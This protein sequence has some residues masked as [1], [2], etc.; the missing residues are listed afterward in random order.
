M[1]KG[2][3]EINYQTLGRVSEIIS[4]AK[5]MT[6]VAQS[7]VAELRDLLGLKGCALMLLDRKTKELEVTAAAGLSDEYLN[8]GPLSAAKSIAASMTDGPV[9]IYNVEDD[10]R[11]QYPQEAVR[12]GVKSILSV[13][14]VLRGKPQGVLRLYTNEPWEFNMRDLTFVQ[15]IAELL[16]LALYTL[17]VTGAHKTS[18]E[19]L[20]GLRPAARPANG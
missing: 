11:L 1:R 9:G 7:V 8:K 16:A 4:S 5:D 12:E 19:A 3:K 2:R 18:L 6:G 15:A 20:K 10:P 13:P 17:R 14:L